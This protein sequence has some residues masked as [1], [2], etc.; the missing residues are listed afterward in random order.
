[1]GRE[2]A[3]GGG[4][5]FRNISAMCDMRTSDTSQE[6]CCTCPYRTIEGVVD[7][8]LV[9]HDRFGHG[10]GCAHSSYVEDTLNRAVNW[11]R[12]IGTNQRNR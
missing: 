2:R 4:M 9:C 1:M 5:R 11:K 12:I 7:L 10:E 6:S 8:A 3:V